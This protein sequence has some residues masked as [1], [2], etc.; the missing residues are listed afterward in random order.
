MLASKLPAPARLVLLALAVVADWPCGKTPERFTPS[1]STLAD[2]TGLSRRTVADHLNIAEA[3][4]WVQRYRPL[5]EK[6]RTDKERTRYRLMVDKA[7][8][9]GALA[10]APVALASAGGALELVQE[11]HQAS[12]PVAHKPEPLQNITRTSS[13]AS[14][15]PPLDEPAPK[16]RKGTRI[17]QPFIVAD[18]MRD[19]ART[20][21]P[22]VVVALENAKFVDYWDAQPGQ[23]GVKLNWQA[24][25][26]NWMRKAQQ[27]AERDHKR[28][29]P[30]ELPPSNAPKRIPAGE[31]CPRGH[32]GEIAR[33]CRVCASERK[34]GIPQP[35]RQPDPTEDLWPDDWEQP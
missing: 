7:S 35:R 23:K 13:L 19:F 11:A 26:R 20:Q 16:A 6:A 4:G 33:N 25:W 22:L 10:S 15:T 14:T 12:A 24:T 3:D 9:G 32:Q 17:P 27:D 1:L 18:E 34:A 28:S 30:R 8:A 31:A 21:T 2:L 5:V 29:Q